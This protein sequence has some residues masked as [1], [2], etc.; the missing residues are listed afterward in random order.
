MQMQKNTKLRFDVPTRHVLSKF[1]P[2]D[3]RRHYALREAL[4]DIRVQVSCDRLEFDRLSIHT[5]VGEFEGSCSKLTKS[6]LFLH[7]EMRRKTLLGSMPILSHLFRERRILAARVS[8]V[9]DPEDGEIYGLHLAIDKS[10]IEQIRIPNVLTA[11]RH[12]IYPYASEYE[13][14]RQTLPLFSFV[15]LH[16]LNCSESGFGNRMREDIDIL[17]TYLMERPEPGIF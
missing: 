9:C 10:Y 13:K 1:H 5:G 11:P 4:E 7:Y 16:K 15:R 2:E 3:A 8:H 17:K 6:E 12:P 14:H